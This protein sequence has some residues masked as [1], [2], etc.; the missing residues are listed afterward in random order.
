MRGSTAR[1][2]TGAATILLV[3][4]LACAKHEPP[5]A[6]SPP[7]LPPDLTGQTVI[8]LPVQAARGVE[9]SSLD[10]ELA[11]WLAD[12][13]RG[14][15][16][17]LPEAIDRALSRSPGMGLDPRALDVSIFFRAEVR[18]IGDPLFGDLRRLGALLD[19]RWAL[20]PVGG[21]YVSQP[22]G[23]GRVEVSAALIDTLRGTVLWFGVAGGEPGD[24]GSPTVV[25]SA[26]QSFARTFIP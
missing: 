1:W 4:A 25:A 15:R 18:R 16:W 10:A 11:Y 14:V 5:S 6:D 26:A 9:P 22:E 19:A 23:S 2:L 21:G 8:L 20:V 17:V 12:R 13:G 24:A 7:P 3:A